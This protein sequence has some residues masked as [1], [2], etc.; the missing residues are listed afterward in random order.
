MSK[1]KCQR[2]IQTSSKTPTNPWI[3]LILKSL[4][5][6]REFQSITSFCIY[7]TYI[8]NIFIE[9]INLCYWVWDKKLYLSSFHGKIKK[10]FLNSG[11]K[12]DWK[13]Q[14]SNNFFLNQLFTYFCQ[15]I[16]PFF[17]HS[18][19]HSLWTILDYLAGFG[20]Q[21]FSGGSVF[22]IIPQSYFKKT[23]SLSDA[24][25]QQ[26]CLCIRYDIDLIGLELGR[27]ESKSEFLKFQQKKM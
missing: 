16:I 23:F 3:L 13:R 12:G 18:R 8:L 20:I 15:K 17:I 21:F 25:I 19:I 14:F 26:F 2:K 22:F 7:I 9:W 24:E 1:N 11:I 10:K 5:K 4:K 6:E 27:T